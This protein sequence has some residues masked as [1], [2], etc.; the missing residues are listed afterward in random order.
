MTLVCVV[1]VWAE[2]AIVTTEDLLRPAPSL[3][4]GGHAVGCGEAHAAGTRKW[5]LN[6]RVRKWSSLTAAGGTPRLDVWTR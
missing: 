6:G 5:M 2:Q 3:V 4:R 1:R